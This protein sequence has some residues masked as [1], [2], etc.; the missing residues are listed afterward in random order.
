MRR[1]NLWIKLAGN[2]GNGRNYAIMDYPVGGYEPSFVLY[3]MGSI[4]YRVSK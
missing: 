4:L 1:E 3:F 2:V